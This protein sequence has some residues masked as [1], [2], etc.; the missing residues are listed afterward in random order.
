MRKATLFIA[1]VAAAFASMSGAA[2]AKNI[3]ATASF[4]KGNATCGG[5]NGGK[6]IGKAKFERLGNTVSVTSFN[7]KGADPLTQYQ[8]EL[9]GGSPCHEITDYGAFSTNKKGVFK[10]KESLPAT[11]ETGETSFFATLYNEAAEEFSDTTA[12]TLR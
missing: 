5:K 12:V 1:V 9:W 2:M 3:T 4:L 11:V 6:V 10:F 8:I 7:T